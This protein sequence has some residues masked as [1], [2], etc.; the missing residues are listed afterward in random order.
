M[1]EAKKPTEIDEIIGRKILNL[2]LSQGLTRVDLAKHMDIS[3][4]QLSKYETAKNRI[5]LSRLLSIAEALNVNILDL[6]SDF[7]KPTSMQEI[8]RQ[9]QCGNLM[10]YFAKMNDSKRETMIL[11]AKTVAEETKHINN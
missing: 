5:S 1:T 9:R 11:I 3:H 4:Q 2:R 6:L 8:E 7:E 10:R